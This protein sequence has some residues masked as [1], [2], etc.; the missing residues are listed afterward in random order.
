MQIIETQEIAA[1]SEGVQGGAG[2]AR[3]GALHLTN[4]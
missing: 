2:G 3:N 4:I 1:G